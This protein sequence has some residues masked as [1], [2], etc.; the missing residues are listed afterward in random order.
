VG[1]DADQ[2]RNT[3]DIRIFSG[4]GICADWQLI[5]ATGFLLVPDLLTP[6]LGR[7]KETGRFPSITARSATPHHQRRC[8]DLAQIVAMV[9]Q[10]VV[11]LAVSAIAI[12]HP[13]WEPY[14]GIPPIKFYAA[15]AK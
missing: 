5:V 3:L 9:R 13:R 12:K 6:M 15:G 7:H 8:E 2:R 14:A 4:S 11:A 10:G 1:L